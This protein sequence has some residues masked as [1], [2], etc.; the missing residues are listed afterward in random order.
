MKVPIGTSS[1]LPVFGR[2]SRES[3]RL[4][5]ASAQ[6]QIG[7]LDSSSLIPFFERHLRRGAERLGRHDDLNQ[8][9]GDVINQA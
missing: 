2:E 3:A 7:R 5:I 4:K 8:S 1:G 6:V 9:G